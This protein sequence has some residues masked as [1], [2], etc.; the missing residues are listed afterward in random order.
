MP[1]FNCC[2]QADGAL[3][4]AS[5]ARQAADASAT[6]L[7]SLQAEAAERQK[8][9]SMLNG[10]F[11]SR[12]G[13]LRQEIE[14]LQSQAADA[15]AAA[16]AAQQQKAL[17]LEVTPALSRHLFVGSSSLLPLPLF[18]LYMYEDE[19]GQQHTEASAAADI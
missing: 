8:R 7:K 13:K 18:S 15:A 19:M 4:E 2:R 9:F 12:E 14:A 3:A 17:A 10:T 1:L 11:K 5:E 6:Q 16:E